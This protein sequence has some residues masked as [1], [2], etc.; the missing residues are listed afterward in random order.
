MNKNSSNTI[1]DT[2]ALFSEGVAAIQ[3][4]LIRPLLAAYES[5]RANLDLARLGTFGGLSAD[6]GPYRLL[7]GGVANISCSGLLMQRPGLLLRILFG[8]SDLAEL[9]YAITAAAQDK[10]VRSVI[11]SIDSP[12]GVVTGPPEIAALIEEVCKE[13]PVLAWSD[14][15]MAS[16]AYWIGSACSSVFVS[17]PTVTTGS[18]GVV[19]THTYAPSQ[20]GSTTTEITA[21]KFK[22]IASGSAPLSPE[23]HAHIQARVDYLAGV[24]HKAV[25]RGRGMSPERVAA[26]EAATYIG[27]QGIDAGLVDGLASFEALS[28]DL[29]ADPARFMRRRQTVRAARSAAPEPARH[30]AHSVAP[31]LASG[32]A[33]K[34]PVA[35]KVEPRTP[36]VGEQKAMAAECIR[37]AYLRHGPDFRIRV[38]TPEQWEHDA[39]ALIAREGCDFAEAMQRVGFVHALVSFPKV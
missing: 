22:R 2:G 32:V 5:Q 21:G 6:A 20:D 12:G 4:E 27:A 15:V 16:A 24:F 38:Q 17:G 9:K 3:P 7:P 30:S 34:A 10:A 19:A 8:A 14:G 11:L 36:N 1:I 29:A 33:A 39:K 35:A 18:V 26:L 25:A 37:K 23:G 31:L 13:K 28:A